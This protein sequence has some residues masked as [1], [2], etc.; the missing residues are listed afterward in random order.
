MHQY[1][2]LNLS[3]DETNEKHNGGGHGHSHENI[4]LPTEADK[5]FVIIEMIDLKIYLSVNFLVCGISCLAGVC[6]CVL[7][8]N[9][10]IKVGS[11]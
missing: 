7:F 2:S 5:Y 9:L 10:V 11:Q 8:F 4:I 3:E 1:D 6:S